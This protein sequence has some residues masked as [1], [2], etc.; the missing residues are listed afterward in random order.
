[1]LLVPRRGKGVGPK[2]LPQPLLTPRRGAAAKLLRHRAYHS[3]FS[4]PEGAVASPP[5]AKLQPVHPVMLLV[6]LRG[7]ATLAASLLGK[8]CT[9]SNISNI[10]P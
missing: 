3:P 10:T 8:G 6:P 5:P 9:E 2:G 1:M 7:T 4:S